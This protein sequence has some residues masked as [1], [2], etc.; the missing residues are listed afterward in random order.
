MDELTMRA[1]LHEEL[2]GLGIRPPFDAHELCALIADRGGREI[3][4]VPRSDL[5][6]SSGFGTLIRFPEK[7]LILYQRRSTGPGQMWIIFHELTHLI[8][9]HVSPDQAGESLL[10][11]ASVDDRRA[12]REQGGSLYD[13]WQEWEAETGAAIL[14]QWANAPARSASLFS[15]AAEERS[16]ARGLGER[17][18]WS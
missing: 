16:V 1:L 2:R 6:T 18:R 9:G 11:G 14:S 15:S 13:A 8:R 12:A 17:E 4:L 5:P 10:C 7:D 3:V